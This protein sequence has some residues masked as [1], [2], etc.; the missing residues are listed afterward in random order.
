MKKSVLR[1]LCACLLMA[2]AVAISA[3]SL[4]AA[5]ADAAERAQPKPLLWV[6]MVL[7]TGAP[8]QDVRIFDEDGQLLQSLTTER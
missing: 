5:F 8:A 1:I 3:V 7:L 6:R 2:M 4:G